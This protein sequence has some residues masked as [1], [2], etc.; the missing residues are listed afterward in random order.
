MT[1]TCKVSK[2][3]AFFFA[4][5]ATAVLFSECRADDPISILSSL[6]PELLEAFSGDLEKNGFH[7]AFERISDESLI[8]GLIRSPPADIPK[9][10]LL[11][12]VSTVLLC[13]LAEQDLLDPCEPAWQGR[14][15]VGLADRER[16]WFGVFGDPITIIFNRSY[17]DE[18]LPLRFLPEG[19]EDLGTR[20]FRDSLIIEKPNHYNVTGYLFACLIDRAEQMYKDRDVGFDLLAAMDRNLLRTYN[21]SE[22]LFY[23]PGSLFSGERGV[24]S[25]ASLSQVDECVKEGKTADIVLPI[26]GLFLYPRGIALLKGA[27]EGAAE[28]YKALTDENRLK[29]L[30]QNRNCYPLIF[31]E[32][33]AYSLFP[34]QRLF[35]DLFKTDHDSVARNIKTWISRWQNT[36]HGR[37]KEKE[38]AI[39]DAVNT[40]MTFLVPLFIVII[41]ITSRKKKTKKK[42]AR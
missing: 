32:N 22:S 1:P 4:L 25:V 17:F 6:E 37:A 20:T 41:I 36:I 19:W 24:I 34:G 14:L 8:P 42:G 15:P 33:F 10:Q 18:D 7:V 27:T 12:G 38:I 16:R 3:L 39:D 21:D 26:E 11:Y 40:T 29:R 23:S 9:P 28:V 2:G 35:L 5:L 31:E 13:H 30:S